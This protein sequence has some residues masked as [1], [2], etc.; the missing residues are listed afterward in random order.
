MWAEVLIY[1]KVA[2]RM[3]LSL[4]QLF[5]VLIPVNSFSVWAVDLHG[6]LGVSLVVLVV[7]LTS[8]LCTVASL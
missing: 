4:I 1:I 8:P 5:G 3:I 6:S 2:F 7:F